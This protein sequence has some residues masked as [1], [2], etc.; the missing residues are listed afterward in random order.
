MSQRETDRLN[1]MVVAAAESRALCTIAELGVADQI[2]PGSPQ[3]VA[4][5]AASTGTH[6][7]SLYRVLRFMASRGVFTETSPG[8]FD[9]TPLSRALRTDADGTFRPAARMF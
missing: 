2:S 3:P 9:H 6:E 1:A 7:R 4:A 5:L 8:E